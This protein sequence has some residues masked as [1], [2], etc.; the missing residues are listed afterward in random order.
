MIENDFQILK[1]FYIIFNDLK[2]L[3]DKREELFNDFIKALE[4]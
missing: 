3:Q 1:Q 4:F 2:Y